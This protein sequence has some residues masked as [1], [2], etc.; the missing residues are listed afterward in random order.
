MPE[1]KQPTG[2]ARSNEKVQKPDIALGKKDAVKARKK[3]GRH[4][5]LDQFNKQTTN[6]KSKKGGRGGAPSA[7]TMFP[8][9]VWI[10]DTNT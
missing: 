10:R 4:A 5:P 6:D 8:I 2:K 1:V 9:R 7:P 3:E